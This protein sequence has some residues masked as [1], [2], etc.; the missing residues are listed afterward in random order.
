ML[1]TLSTHQ[2]LP[3]EAVYINFRNIL[4]NIPS[5]YMV[6]DRDL[7]IVYANPAYLNYVERSLDDVLGQYIF[8]CFPE[9]EKRVNAVKERFLKTLEGKVTLL[10][11]QYFQFTHADGSTSEKCWQCVQ[12]PYYGAHGK[13]SYIIQH[14]DDITTAEELRQK[15]E[16]IAREMDHRVKNTFSVVQAVASLAG[17]GAADIDEFREQFNSRLTAMSRTHS[18]LCHKDW[19]GLLLSEIMKNE[20]EQYGGV[21]S[22][23]ICMKGP[24]ILLGPKSSQDASMIIHELATNAA[25]YGC[26]SRPEGRLGLSW[27]T[28]RSTQ[29]LIVEWAETGMSG[30]TEPESK[31]F[32]TQLTELMPTI[33]VERIYRDEGLL[34][35]TS[36]PLAIAT[37]NP[38]KRSRL[39]RA[40]LPRMQRA[41]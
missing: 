6:M 38:F 13:V 23:R 20:L 2:G 22:D 33:E 40:G 18:A 9:D 11:R 41:N 36:V 4:D 28:E 27:W 7:H 19:N 10:D 1:E 25:K 31:G 39:R 16:M 37:R 12:T 8:D 3:A 26:F 21:P 17:Q 24:D 29:T 30:I 34:V 14:A 32:G 5:A 15:Y 35:R